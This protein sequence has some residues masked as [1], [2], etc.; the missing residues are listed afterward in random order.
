MTRLATKKTPFRAW[1]DEQ[2]RSALTYDV[3]IEYRDRKV[4]T[5]ENFIREGWVRGLDIRIGTV[6]KWQQGAAPRPGFLRELRK[7]F[8][9]IRF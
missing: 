3:N 9:S 1:L 2:S 6:M 5:V 4:W 7:K 8:P